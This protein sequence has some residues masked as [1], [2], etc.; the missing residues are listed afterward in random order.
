MDAE[1]QTRDEWLADVRKAVEACN[2][3]VGDSDEYDEEAHGD[4]LAAFDDQITVVRVEWMLDAIDHLRGALS[5]IADAD[6]K[7]QRDGHGFSHHILDEQ[8]RYLGHAAPALQRIAR[9]ALGR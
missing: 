7:Y 4:A 3:E 9:D 8:G 1:V 5:E 2:A 6:V